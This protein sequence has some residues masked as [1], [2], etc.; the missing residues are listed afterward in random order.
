VPG[1]QPVRIKA[2]HLREAHGPASAEL[3]EAAVE[4]RR[5]A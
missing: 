5:S 3:R 4:P 1:D 2:F